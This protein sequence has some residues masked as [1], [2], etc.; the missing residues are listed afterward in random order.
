MARNRISVRCRIGLVQQRSRLVEGNHSVVDHLKEGE[1]RADLALAAKGKQIDFD[2]KALAGR[3]FHNRETSPV[4]A[5]KRPEVRYRYSLSVF[6][7]K[8]V[9]PIKPDAALFGLKEIAEFG[10]SVYKLAVPVDNA[11]GE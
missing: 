1:N 11:D 9:T 5:A 6:G 8:G 2:G 4:I 3:S 10:V 7:R